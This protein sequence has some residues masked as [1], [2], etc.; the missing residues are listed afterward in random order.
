VALRDDAAISLRILV[1]EAFTSSDMRPPDSVELGSRIRCMGF[2]VIGWQSLRDRI[3]RS[4]FRMLVS[5][6]VGVVALSAFVYA[7]QAALGGGREKSRISAR[8]RVAGKPFRVATG[9]G[10][11]WA[12]S[13]T[14]PG[15]CSIRRPCFVSRIDPKS[16]RVVGKPTRLPVAPW[17]LTVGAGSVWVTPNGADGRLTRIDARTAR[18]TARISARPNYFGGEA[19]FGAGF[20]WTGNDD[21]R[22]KQ[23]STVSKIDPA[24]NRVVGEPLVLGSPQSITFGAGAV[25]VADHNGWLVRIDPVTFKV[26]A[27]QRLNFGPHGVVAKNT[28]VYVADAHGSRVLEADPK[29]ARIRRVARLSIA[30]IYP[31]AG[32]GSLWSGSAAAWEEPLTRDDRVIRINPTALRI[33]ETLHVGGN[34]SAVAFGFGS[35][36]AA[37][38]AGQVVRIAPRG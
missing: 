34:V 4:T 11:V 3:G 6:I 16:N 2:V 36:W 14:T 19:V 24:T 9:A 23:G 7:D 29:T 8:I 15:A 26:V 28:A 10:Y 21:E 31:A 32:A 1:V 13:R 17:D 12:L 37:L 33:V 30:P 25:W 22:Y 27:R 5:G 35:L 38:P 18:I 20:I